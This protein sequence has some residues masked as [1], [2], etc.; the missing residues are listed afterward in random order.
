MCSSS[1]QGFFFCNF[2]EGVSVSG[3]ASPSRWGLAMV[4]SMG[5]GCQSCWLVCRAGLSMLLGVLWC[6]GFSEQNL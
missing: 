4:V 2:V 5:E 1:C 3:A 6:R